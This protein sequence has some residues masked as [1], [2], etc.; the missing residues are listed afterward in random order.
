M[1]DDPLA[2]RGLRAPERSRMLVATEDGVFL[3]PGTPLVYRV[4]N[5]FFAAEPR[6]L[7]SAIGSLFGPTALDLPLQSIL[8]RARDELRI[9]RVSG[10][11]ELLDKFPLLPISPNGARLMRAVADRQGLAVPNFAAATHQVGTVWSERE[12]AAFASLYDCV[13]S[14]ARELSKVFNPGALNPPSLWDPEKHPRQPAG[15]SDGG[16]FATTGGGDSSIIPVAGPP[17]PWHNNPPERIGDPP[18]IPEKEPDTTAAKFAVI[19]SV[20][21]WIGN[22]V[23]FGSKFAGPVKALIAA[24]QTVAWL[25]PYIS[26]YLQGPKTLEELQ[27]DAKSPA[28]G[29]DIHHVVEQTPADQDGYA[30]T[31]IESPRNKVRIP[32]IKHWQ[33][34]AWFNTANKDYG[35]LTPRQ[36][37]RDKPWFERRRVGLAGLRAVGVLK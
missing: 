23:K 24:A 17:P 1:L 4:G 26:A 29:Y 2:G 15:E 22:A 27:A 9:G 21:Y 13:S 12:I 6:A 33:L 14:R 35:G 31:L 20:A 8:D 28:A 36:Y 3:W 34:N 37:V 32:A 11:Q 19:R 7:N 5:G 30:R 10:A 18:K 25:K 16:E